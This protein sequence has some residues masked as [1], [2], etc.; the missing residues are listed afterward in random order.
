ME[1]VD[2]EKENEKLYFMC[3]QDWSEEIKEA[4]NHKEN[5]YIKIRKKGLRV[6]LARDDR[7]I[8]GGMIQY[9]PIEHSFAWGIADG[10]FVNGKKIRTGPPPSYEK[11]RRIIEKSV[12]KKMKLYSFFHNIINI[13]PLPDVC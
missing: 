4:G 7:G 1:V 5:W 13:S 6:K 9:C 10:I 8:I 11:I 12:R 3:L 2:L